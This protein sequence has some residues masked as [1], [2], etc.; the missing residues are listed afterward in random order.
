MKVLSQAEGLRDLLS[1]RHIG[2]RRGAK[3]SKASHFVQICFPRSFG[4]FCDRA[5]LDGS[6]QPAVVLV[7]ISGLELNSWSG[8]G[9]VI[10][11]LIYHIR[12]L[13]SRLLPKASCGSLVHRCLFDFHLS[14]L[15]ADIFSSV[16]TPEN[17]DGPSH[18]TTLQFS[19]AHPVFAEGF[20]RAGS[21]TDYIS[22]SSHRCS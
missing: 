13:S 17:L 9:R 7:V 11:G 8:S 10:V 12:I 14:P 16:T 2:Y 3:V 5:A 1:D 18:P 4:D 15:T 20:Q 21:Q 19:L 6:S 22:G